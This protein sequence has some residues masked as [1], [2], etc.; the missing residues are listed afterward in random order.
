MNEG[1][2]VYLLNFCIRSGKKRKLKCN[3]SVRI[4][5]AEKC[6]KWNNCCPPP[7]Q[8]IHIAFSWSDVLEQV[9]SGEVPLE[10]IAICSRNTKGG[11]LRDQPWRSFQSVWRARAFT[12]NYWFEIR[13][14]IAAVSVI[15]T[16]P[17]WLCEFSCHRCEEKWVNWIDHLKEQPAQVGDVQDWTHMNSWSISTIPQ[18]LNVVKHVMLMCLYTFT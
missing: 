7:V 4:C 6:K 15:A 1:S 10:R 8:I 9:H 11:H 12:V 17:N 16:K 5:E 2:G 14:N 18:V 13:Q 3:S